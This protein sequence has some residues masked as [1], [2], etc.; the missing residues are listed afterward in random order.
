MRPCTSRACSRRRRTGFCGGGSHAVSKRRTEPSPEV[1]V[2][3][4]SWD[5][6]HTQSKSV[7]EVEKEKI[8]A[9]SGGGKVKDD[10]VATGDGDEGGNGSGNGRRR[11]R[12]RRKKKRPPYIGEGPLVP[13]PVNA[14]D[15]K[16]FS[17]GW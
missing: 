13:A 3:R 14:R 8:G 7:S 5:S 17:P 12:V 11:R 9:R 10:E 4:E 1:V 15:K 2:Q 6:N 16:T